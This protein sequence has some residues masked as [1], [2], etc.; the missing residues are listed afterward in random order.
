MR[1][2]RPMGLL[3]YDVT[4]DRLHEVMRLND[5]TEREAIDWVISV[6]HIVAQRQSQTRARV[7]Q[8]GVHRIREAQ[9]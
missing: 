8:A 4:V 7:Y 6:G 2:S 1:R 5:M 3:I 9:Q